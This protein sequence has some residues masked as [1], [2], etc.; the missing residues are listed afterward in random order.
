MKIVY[1]NEDLLHDDA[2]LLLGEPPLFLP[3]LLLHELS[4]IHVAVLKHY[5]KRAVVI[6]DALGVDDVWVLPQLHQAAE[7][8]DLTDIKGFFLR[9]VVLLHFLHSDYLLGG[10]VQAL[11]DRAERTR[12]YLVQN[13]IL[14]Q[15]QVFWGRRMLRGR[16]RDI[17][18]LGRDSEMDGWCEHCR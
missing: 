16:R 5:V 18:C 6:F 17:S 8:L 1:S 3:Q 7:D 14:V 2:D 9:L 11:V 10:D 4:E 13:L 12:A 15:H